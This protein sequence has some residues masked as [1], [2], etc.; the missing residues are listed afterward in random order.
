MGWYPHTEEELMECGLITKNMLSRAKKDDK[1]VSVPPGYRKNNQNKMCCVEK[2]DPKFH[3]GDDLTC[4]WSATLILIDIMCS[5][6]A[7]K[8]VTLRNEN[9]EKF[10]NIYLFKQSQGRDS[11]AS[12]L[13]KNTRFELQKL[14][15]I[16]NL[17]QKV[18][19]VMMQDK[20]LFICVIADYNG[21]TNHCIGID[22]GKNM[23]YDAVDLKAKWLTKANI[24]F[25]TGV[26]DN[27][28]GGGF[29]GFADVA[30]IVRKQGK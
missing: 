5:D 12:L 23:I 8:M 15:N 22:C 4:A 20:G 25:S 18:D 9:P 16:G 24:E 14:K 28:V 19:Y 27:N 26:Y 2:I 13:Q 3:Q 29:A 21:S 17:M 30:K 11:V 7:D 1:V 10:S 6:T